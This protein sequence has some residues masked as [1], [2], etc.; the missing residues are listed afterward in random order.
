MCRIGSVSKLMTWVWAACVASWWI[1]AQ[2][3][4]LAVGVRY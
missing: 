4:L 1:A 2:A 3:N